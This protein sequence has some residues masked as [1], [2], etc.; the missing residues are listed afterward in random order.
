MLRATPIRREANHE[1]AA[2]L[3]PDRIAHVPGQDVPMDDRLIGLG[4]GHPRPGARCAPRRRPRSFL[5]FEDIGAAVP[6]EPSARLARLDPVRPVAPVSGWADED[7]VTTWLIDRR[8]P[9]WDRFIPRHEPDVVTE[10]GEASREARD[11]ILGQC[12]CALAR[13]AVP[14]SL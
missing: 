4:S 3:D 2:V 5:L 9:G 6:A 10:V 12:R 13:R 11:L 14:H 1:D 8:L 7:V